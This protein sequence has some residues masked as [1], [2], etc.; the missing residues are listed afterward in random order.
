MAPWIEFGHFIYLFIQFISLT[1]NCKNKDIYHARYQH[2]NISAATDHFG[3]HMFY[4]CDF[5]TLKNKMDHE[6]KKAKQRLIPFFLFFSDSTTAKNPLRVN[7]SGFSAGFELLI[8][9]M[10]EGVGLFSWRGYSLLKCREQIDA[11]TIVKQLQYVHVCW[12][13]LSHS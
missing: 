6:N 7:I 5:S 2:N 10:T 1:W 3:S 4:Y 12:N 9:W 11:T 13:R 8:L